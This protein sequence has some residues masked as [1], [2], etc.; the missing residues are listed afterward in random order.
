MHLAARLGVPVMAF[1]LSSAWC[2]E[3]GPYGLGHHVLQATPE[4][5]PCLETAP[6]PHDVACRRV[7]A[8]PAVL[9]RVSGRDAGEMP[10]GCALMTSG[11]DGLGATFTAVAG[12]DAGAVRRRAFRAM[13]AACAGV[14]VPG[15]GT[16]AADE[17]WMMERDWMLP[18][19]LRGRAHE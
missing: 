13:A 16:Q 18:Q 3:T 1:F 17:S 4:C 6:C 11:F 2:H 9:R 12:D 19:T 14:P 8:D 10:A 5:A 15:E 7:F